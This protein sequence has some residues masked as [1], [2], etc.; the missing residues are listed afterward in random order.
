MFFKL[1]YID[2]VSPLVTNPPLANCTTRKIHLFAASSLL[3]PIRF[4]KIIKL[5][6][7]FEFRM[8]YTSFCSLKKYSQMHKIL[9]I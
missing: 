7:P 2:E 5:K 1:Y 6:I 9:R 3:I 4:E 8:D